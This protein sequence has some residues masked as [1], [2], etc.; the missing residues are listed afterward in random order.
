MS[1]AT[2]EHTFEVEAPARLKVSNIRGHVD[3]QPGEDG[4]IRITVVKHKSSGINGQIHGPGRLTPGEDLFP[5]LPSI[6]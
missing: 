1:T 6:H 2:F 3:V 5:G 4:I